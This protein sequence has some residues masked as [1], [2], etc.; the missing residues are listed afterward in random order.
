MFR[1]LKMKKIYPAHVSKHNSNREQVIFLLI[2]NGETCHYL[3]IN[4]KNL[5]KHHLLFAQIM[6]VS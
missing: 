1:M 4:I 2:S 6:N 3:E 5:V